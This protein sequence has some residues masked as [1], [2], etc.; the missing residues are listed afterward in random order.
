M[1]LDEQYE[2][3]LANGQAALD[4]PRPAAVLGRAS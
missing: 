1:T 4:R 3:I 2:Q